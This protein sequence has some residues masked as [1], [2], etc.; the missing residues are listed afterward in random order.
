MAIGIH[1]RFSDFNGKSSE[2]AVNE[3]LFDG[4]RQ[5]RKNDDVDAGE[6]KKRFIICKDCRSN[7]WTENGR[8]INEYE[9]NSCSAFVT[10]LGEH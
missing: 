7:D 9:C 1:F 8:T 2:F 4:E 6:G 3:F 10:V 5:Y